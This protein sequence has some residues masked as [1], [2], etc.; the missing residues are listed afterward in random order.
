VDDE[1]SVIVA[2]NVAGSLL[3]CGFRSG[4]RE[5]DIDHALGSTLRFAIRASIMAR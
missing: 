1:F 5:I 4:A 3:F 2:G